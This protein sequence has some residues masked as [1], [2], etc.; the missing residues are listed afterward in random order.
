MKKRYTKKQILESI[1]YWKKMLEEEIES[2]TEKIIQA[3]AVGKL[4][5]EAVGSV[6]IYNDNGI[7]WDMPNSQS[8]KFVIIVSNIDRF[9]DRYICD[10]M[11]G[12]D[13]KQFQDFGMQDF[14]IDN[15]PA[16]YDFDDIVHNASSKYGVKLGSLNGFRNALDA[17]N[18]IES[19]YEIKENKMKKRYT[20]R[21]IQESI[22]YWKKQLNMM[23][24]DE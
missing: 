21:Q 2:P 19:S 24:E 23:N 8:N 22:A 3:L 18:N 17:H 12:P 20:K 7:F 9:N 4:N 1:K 15:M 16:Q 13:N 10:V 6:G 14:S 5:D 11:G